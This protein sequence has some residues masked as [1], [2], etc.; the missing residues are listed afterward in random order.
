MQEII[1]IGVIK[2]VKTINSIDI[3]SI[4]NLNLIKLFIQKFSSTNWN[5]EEVTSNEYHRNSES[6]NTAKLL[7]KDIYIELLLLVLSLDKKMKRELNKGKNIKVD[8]IGKF[9]LF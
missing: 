8:N 9:I 7:N 3:P 4:P 6:R 2:V 1:Q 5:S